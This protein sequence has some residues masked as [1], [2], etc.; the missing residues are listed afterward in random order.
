MTVNLLLTH[1]HFQNSAFSV[2]RGFYSKIDFGIVKYHFE[3]GAG[4]ENYRWG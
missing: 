4:K 3:L 1:H 2:G